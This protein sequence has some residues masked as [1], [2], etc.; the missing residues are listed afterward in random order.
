MPTRRRRMS[1]HGQLMILNV[2]S[3]ITNDPKGMRKAMYDSYYED[4]LFDRVT[5]FFS[6]LMQD[7]SCDRVVVVGWYFV[8]IFTY[9]YCDITG[10]I[11]DEYTLSDSIFDIYG[12]AY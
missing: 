4:N 9:I 1:T 10:E 11:I 7:S 12:S 3:I 6:G 5:G 2:D 8:I